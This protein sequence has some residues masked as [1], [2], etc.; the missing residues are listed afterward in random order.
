MDS[1]KP[2]RITFTKDAVVRVKWNSGLDRFHQLRSYTGMIIMSKTEDGGADRRW[3]D[4]QDFKIVKVD[5]STQ[6][7]VKKNLFFSSFDQER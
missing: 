4:T 3:L 5:Y 2:L 1:F 6:A 7:G